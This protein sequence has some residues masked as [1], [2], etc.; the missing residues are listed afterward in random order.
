MNKNL[1]IIPQT[2]GLV[3]QLTET[4]EQAK[5]RIEQLEEKEMNREMEYLKVHNEA[6]ELFL[7][8]NKDY[9][10]AFAKYGPVGVIVRIGDKIQ[11]LSS[12]TKNGVQLVNNES[13]RDTLIDLHNYAA[14]AVMLL[15]EN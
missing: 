8:K 14:M 5:Y 2:N 11:R 1:D 3:R 10:D 13:I 12:V 4:P 15:D 6:F 7:K 9:G